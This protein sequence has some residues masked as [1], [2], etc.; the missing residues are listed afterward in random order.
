MERKLNEQWIEVIDGKMHMYKAVEGPCERCDISHTCNLS[1]DCHI[2]C[3]LIAK[4]LGILNEDGCLPSDFG[5]YPEVYEHVLVGINGYMAKAY[6]SDPHVGKYAWG[7]TKQEA[8]DAW[9]RRA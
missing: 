5:V 2:E 6:I 7:K 3:G 9:N 1:A 4:D 8:V